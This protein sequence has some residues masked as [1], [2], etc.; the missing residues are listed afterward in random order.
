MLYRVNFE[1]RTI[2]AQGFGTGNC[3]GPSEV[4]ALPCCVEEDKQSI[5][6]I[7]LLA[8]PGEAKAKAMPGRLY[9]HIKRIIIINQFCVIFEYSE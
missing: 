6:D 1:P 7:I 3:F 4:C 8:T 2:P 5:N 9:I